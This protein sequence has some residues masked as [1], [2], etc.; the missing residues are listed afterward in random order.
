MWITFLL[1]LLT[2]Y[3]YYVLFGF[4]RDDVKG[5]IPQV[6]HSNANKAFDVPEKPLRF[7]CWLVVFVHAVLAAILITTVTS[8]WVVAS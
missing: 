6:A 2:W 7:A 5:Y 3:P 1:K 8:I 4:L